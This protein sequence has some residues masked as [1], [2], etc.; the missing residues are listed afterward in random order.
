[1]IKNV[2]ILFFTSI[3]IIDA[4]RPLYLSIWQIRWKNQIRR[5]LKSEVKKNYLITFTFSKNDL[6]NKIIRIQFIRKDEFRLNNQM[7]DIVRTIE[8]KDSVSY[9]CYLDL[10]EMMQISSLMNI[11]LN[12]GLLTPLL[13]ILKNNIVQFFYY[14]PEN[15]FSVAS[16]TMELIIFLINN[17]HTIFREIE[18]KLPPP[19]YFHCQIF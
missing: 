18:V 1:M 5:E 8:S 13:P 14:L 17:L 16:Y 19:K 3:L 10:K 12:S 15:K 4:C 9:I 11:A 7:Y 6:K 2:I